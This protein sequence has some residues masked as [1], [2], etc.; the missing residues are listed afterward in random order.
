LTKQKQLDFSAHFEKRQMQLVLLIIME[1]TKMFF[2]ETPGQLGPFYWNK[3]TICWPG[4]PALFEI[5]T[6]QAGQPNGPRPIV[7]FFFLGL[8][9]SNFV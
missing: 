4:W 2:A 9:V 6:L 1:S 5:I 8:K 7:D 3:S